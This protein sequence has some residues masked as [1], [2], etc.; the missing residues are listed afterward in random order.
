MAIKILRLDH[1]ASDL[2][3]EASKTRH[4][5][6]ARRLLALALVL[7]GASRTDAA[8]ACGMDRQTLGGWVHRCNALGIDGLVDRKD[9]GPVPRLTSQEEAELAQIVERGPDIAHD[10]IVRWRRA[11]LRDVIAAR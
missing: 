4:A 11:D 9:A 5:D 6:Q 3:R 10:G 8:T 2:R 1:T 7:E